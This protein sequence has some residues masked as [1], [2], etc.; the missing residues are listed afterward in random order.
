MTCARRRLRWSDDQA[1]DRSRKTRMPPVLPRRRP[2][3]PLTPR[4]RHYLLSWPVKPQEREGR[5]RTRE[6]ERSWN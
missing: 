2:A 5:R 4:L 3:C 1:H 6:E